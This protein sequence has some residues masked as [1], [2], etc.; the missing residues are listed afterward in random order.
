MEKA[1]ISILF[2]LVV[3]TKIK[4]YVCPRRPQIAPAVCLKLQWLYQLC[5]PMCI[6]GEGTLVWRSVVFI[7]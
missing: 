7:V 1:D 5:M 2:E 3:G 4:T 6:N